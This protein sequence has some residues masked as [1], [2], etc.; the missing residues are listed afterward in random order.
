MS[1][2]NYQDELKQWIDEVNPL[3]EQAGLRQ[4]YAGQ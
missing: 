3:L 2:V 4:R 1:W